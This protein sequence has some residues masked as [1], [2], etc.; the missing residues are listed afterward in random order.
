MMKKIKYFIKK[1]FRYLMNDFIKESF[2]GDLELF[3][4]NLSIKNGDG[5]LTVLN[6]QQDGLTI[7]TENPR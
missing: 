2:V 6:T 7:R 5:I 4:I 1:V 3:E